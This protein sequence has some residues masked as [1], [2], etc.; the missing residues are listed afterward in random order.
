MKLNNSL[1]PKAAWLSQGVAKIFKSPS[2][3]E[4]MEPLKQ[5]NDDL[6]N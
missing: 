4:M 1:W 3:S 6:V 5:Y 2:S